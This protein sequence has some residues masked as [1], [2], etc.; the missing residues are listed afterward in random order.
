MRFFSQAFLGTAACLS[1]TAAYSQ[2]GVGYEPPPVDYA[3]PSDS[4]APTQPQ[5]SQVADPVSDAVS[6][7]AAPGP[8]RLR[9]DVG[10]YAELQAGV[11]AELGDSNGFGD[12][13]LTYT[14]V[15]AGVDGQIATRRVT[16]N[17]G[18][19]YERRIELNGDLP[20]DEVHS[21]IAAVRAHVT[22]ALSVE[23]AGIATR[24]GGTGRA[25]GV[26]DNE[27]TT[28]V[29]AGYAGPTLQTQ[30]GPVGINAFYRLGYIHVDDDSLAAGPQRERAFDS[31]IHMAGVSA[32]IAP[33]GGRP[34]ATVSAGHAA[35]SAGRFETEFES[36]FVRGDVVLPV[37]PTF[38]VSA[39]IGYSRGRASERDVRR[40]A[41]GVPIFDGDGNLFP[42]PSGPR[43]TVYD[44]DGVFAD[45]GFI[46]RP[47]PRSELQ[48]RAG[49]NDDGDP[50]VLGSAAFQFGRNFGFSFSLY[51][52]DE[53]FGSALIRNLKDLPDEFRVARDPLT[54][55]VAPGCVFSDDTPGRGTCL[56]AALQS[57]TS[58]SYRARGGQ[59]VFSGLGRRWSWGG[60]VTYARRDFYLP[61]DPL[62]ASAYA[63]SDQDFAIFGQ[64]SRA[65]SRNSDISFDAFVSAFDSDDNS[66]DVTSVGLRSSF[67]RSFL[68][69]RLQLLLALG[70]I[71]R[72]SI[73]SD[74]IVLDGLIGLRYTF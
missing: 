48:L 3:G 29:Y 68:L 7:A 4:V 11:S 6:P 17:F 16:A 73:N 39:G 23:A 13:T 47:T 19:R 36:S 67:S 54:G 62:F 46:W 27:G 53:T 61:D 60:G 1:A 30:A 72:S 58:A 45:A 38:A 65:L 8:R 34:G 70:V 40:D 32:G 14:G 41:N 49:I 57:I 59:V 2:P 15:A 18:Y 20:D 64:A 33:S 52:N 44:Q 56:S 74:S 63:P 37:N 69:N 9:V 5:P 71:N 10:A 22:P 42:D 31:T 25:F 51:D 26:T 21:G 66:L 28:G 24:T 12:D 35:V 50:V 55:G 43:V